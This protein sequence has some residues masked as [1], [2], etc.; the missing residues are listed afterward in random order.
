M[1]FSLPDDLIYIQYESHELDVHN[2][3]DLVKIEIKH[4]ESQLIIHWV[5]NQYAD[6]P[7]ILN[8]YLKFIGVEDYQFSSKEAVYPNSENTCISSIRMFKTDNSLIFQIDLQSG[9]EIQINCNDC[10]F[11]NA[12]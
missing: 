8:F 9:K 12:S 1:N 4:D 2:C 10:L 7:E 6:S 3:Y 11:T 5:A